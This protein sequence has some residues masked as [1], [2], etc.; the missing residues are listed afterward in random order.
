MMPKVASAVISGERPPMAGGIEGTMPPMSSREEIA[1]AG[2]NCSIAS[3][4]S[5]TSV[6]VPTSTI[7]TRSITP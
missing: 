4:R 5:V 1:H 6:N 7:D 2:S 3:A